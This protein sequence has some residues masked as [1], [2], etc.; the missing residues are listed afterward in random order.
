MRFTIQN[1]ATIAN[2]PI[3]TVRKWHQTMG[4]PGK[5]DGT[6]IYIDSDDWKRWAAAKLYRAANGR[7]RKR[8]ARSM[9][10][11]GVTNSQYIADAVASAGD[12]HPVME[13]RRLVRVSMYAARVERGEPIFA[14]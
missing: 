1:I 10:R 8:N 11:T 13:A 2:V 12:D 6:L 14:T 3:C 9:K 4:L 7:L 5:R